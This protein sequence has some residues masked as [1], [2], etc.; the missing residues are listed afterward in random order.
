MKMKNY[1]S[2]RKTL[3]IDISDQVPFIK[4]KD[5][6]PNEKK[7]KKGD[8]PILGYLKTRSSKYNTDNYSLLVNVKGDYYLMNVPLWYGES[9]AEDFEAS[10][11]DALTF[12]DDAY[13][14]EIE[15][16]ETKSGNNT[17][18]IVIYED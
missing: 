11:V 5:L 17:F 15:E 4:I 8:V 2:K 6:F 10:G 3:T 13:I 9:L 16:I 12:F 14:K 18:N 7:F 1:S